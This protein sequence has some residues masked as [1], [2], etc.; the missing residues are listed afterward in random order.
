M[1]TQA[2]SS[3]LKE[4]PGRHEDLIPILQKIQG[5]EGY[6]SRESVK[7][8]ARK[9]RMSENEIYGVVTF[10]AQFRLNPPG[11][12]GI[13]VCMGTACHVRGSQ[14]IMEAL[15]R[16]LEIKEGSI[17]SDLKFSLDSV[18]CLGCCGLAPVIT[19]GEDLYGKL[20][21]SVIKRVLKKY[22]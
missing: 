3:I 5:A 10:Y 19:V 14:Q 11:K 8:V 1:S 17:T 15:E 16:E 20:K 7:A 12:H 21:Q 6:I 22:D 13:K 9:L 4:Y 2:A 18:F